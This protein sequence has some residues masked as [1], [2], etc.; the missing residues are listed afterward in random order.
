MI[1]LISLSQIF[2]HSGDGVYKLTFIT[3]ALILL[4]LHSSPRVGAPRQSV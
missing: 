2:L 1:L 4:P 3:I